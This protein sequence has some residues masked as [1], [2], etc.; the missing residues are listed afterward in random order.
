LSGEAPWIVGF[1]AAG[2]IVDLGRGVTGFAIHDRV[3]FADS[4]FAYAEEIAMPAAKLVSL[5]G[6]ISYEAAATLLQGLTA[7]CL[8]RESLCVAKGERELVHAAAGGGPAAGAD[9]DL[10]GGPRPGHCFQGVQDF[11]RSFGWS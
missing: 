6:D 7:H 5:P 3:A 2:E 11:I 1:E 4:P 8:V 9:S 10:E